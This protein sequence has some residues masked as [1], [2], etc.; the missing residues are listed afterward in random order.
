MSALLSDSI[1]RRKIQVK[2]GLITFL[3]TALGM[4]QYVDE[5]FSIL[6]ALHRHEPSA[7]IFRAILEL[8]LVL[9]GVALSFEIWSR[10]MSVSAME[11][12]F[13]PSSL[14]DRT[15]D[16]LPT[17]VHAT[18]MDYMDDEVIFSKDE[19]CKPQDDDKDTNV[20]H[21]LLAE[22]E[23][24]V[25]ARYP[26]TSIL[27]PPHERLPSS[28]T[29]LGAALDTLLLTL[30]AL[31]CF[32]YS[33][34]G[35][36]RPID[37]ERQD[38]WMELAARITGPTFP[39]ILF[40]YLAGRMILPPLQRKPFWRVLSY[41]MA[42]PWYEVT[43]RDGFVGDILT[44]TVRPFQDIL[45]TMI[46]LLYGLHGWWSL[47]YFT[48]TSNNNTTGTS[49]DPSRMVDTIVLPAME[50]SW[51]VHTL[52]L[53]MCV[54]LPLWWRFLQTLRQTYDSRQ[55][56][57]YLGNALKYFVAAQVGILGVY[58]PSW[59]SHPYWLSAYVLATCYQI[60][61]DVFM[62]WNLLERPVPAASLSPWGCF[63][64]RSKRVFT[65]VP[66]YWIIAIINV[67]LRFVW[68]LSF[69][70]T[71]YLDP[72]GILVVRNRFLVSPIIASAEIIRRTLWGILRF[73]WEFIK[74][75]CNTVD[76]F[77]T[78]GRQGEEDD[79]HMEL[80]ASFPGQPPSSRMDTIVLMNDRIPTAN[81]RSWSSMSV[82]ND[83]HV[84]GELG[85]YAAIFLFLWFI[86]A[87]HRAT[88]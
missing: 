58:H 30:V 20:D 19:A 61:W 11:Q 16:P 80:A 83:V 21:H 88:M 9:F 48:T 73:E 24:F 81:A 15:Y 52:L 46:Y 64:I 27:H 39:L 45:Y 47:G 53:P 87:S 28:A 86:A 75:R 42:A 36:K 69:L 76:N 7:R 26:T 12:L 6:D 23:L 40:L 84:L 60:G 71:R 17:R 67:I 85:L 65:W 68:I 62:D 1:R 14:L 33:A 10:T 66:V 4:L 56:W 59:Q 41:T 57:P 70:P 49:T 22:E 74:T 72:Q 55:R 8:T 37:R 78:I 5:S 25:D 77:D 2:V 35:W 38:T 79:D 34:I 54:V 29:V 51:M 31:F 63:R 13:F 43:F 82:L 3:L 18:G 44:S 50:K 32:C